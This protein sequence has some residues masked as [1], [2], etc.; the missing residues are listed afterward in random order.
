MPQTGTYKPSVL[1]ELI[2]PEQIETHGLI[3][4]PIGIQTATTMYV[5]NVQRQ[6]VRTLQHQVQE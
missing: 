4:K 3:P 2:I 1:R 6:A 5:R